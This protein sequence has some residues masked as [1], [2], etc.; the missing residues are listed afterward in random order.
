VPAPT[1]LA[2]TPL[3]APA[4][5]VSSSKTGDDTRRSRDEGGAA[6][7]PSPLAPAVDLQSAQ[8]SGAQTAIQNVPS[9]QD[10]TAVPAPPQPEAPVRLTELAQAA[11]TAIKISSQ[12]GDTSARITLHP[13]E[14]GSVDIHLRYGSDGITATVRADSPQAAQVLHQA[15]PDLKRSLEAQG[16]SLLGFDVRDRSGQPADG[17]P[18][19][20][21]SGS[22]NGGGAHREPDDELTG[23]AGPVLNPGHVPAPGTQIDVFA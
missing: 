7:Q 6:E 18:T 21:Q 19:G 2:A 3:Q 12:N 17:D 16:M 13:N 15:A 10:A 9:L 5:D 14:L 11:Q 22:N 20:K 8:Q 4:D 1:D 23:V